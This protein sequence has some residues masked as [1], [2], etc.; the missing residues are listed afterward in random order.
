MFAALEGSDLKIPGSMDTEIMLFPVAAIDLK[1]GWG[2]VQVEPAVVQVP[3]FVTISLGSGT[4][5][6]SFF[7]LRILNLDVADADLW[8]LGE[9]TR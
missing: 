8:P 3:I 6:V 7:V 1:D 2:L 5:L 9:I 4:L